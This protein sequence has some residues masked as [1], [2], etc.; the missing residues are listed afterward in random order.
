M[1]H[2]GVYKELASPECRLNFFSL[3]DSKNRRF[4]SSKREQKRYQDLL[5][6]KNQAYMETILNIKKEHLDQAELKKL[7]FK[8]VLFKPVLYQ[9][10]YD[11]FGH[12]SH[13]SYYIDFLRISSESREMKGVIGV[14]DSILRDELF[15][16]DVLIK[17]VLSADKRT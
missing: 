7:N 15:N 12:M 4:N 16:K 2:L 6:K 3:V 9:T 13:P 8:N 10:L 11:E 17:R 5:Q 14:A 1:A